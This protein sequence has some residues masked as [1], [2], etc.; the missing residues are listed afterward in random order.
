MY[1]QVAMDPLARAFETPSERTTVDDV[2]DCVNVAEVMALGAARLAPEVRNYLL[3]AAGDEETAAGNVDAFRR[4]RLRPRVLADLDGLSTA[5]SVLGTSVSMP[6]GI[7]PTAEHGLFHPDGEVGMARAAAE[8][9]VPFCVSTASSRPL[10]EIVAA[11]RA[12][13]WFQLYAGPDRSSTE[14]LVRRAVEAGCSAIV[15]TADVAIVG[16]R[17]REFASRRR[18]PA[19]PYYDGHWGHLVPGFDVTRTG[20][21][22]TWSDLHWLLEACDGCPLVL[23]GVLTA[24]DA[25]LAV[26]HGVSAIWVSN[27]GGRQ[28]DRTPAT[29]DVL[30]EIVDA[31]GRTEVYLDGGIR[32]GIDA[33]TALALG[34]RCVFVGR[35]AVLGLAADGQ[36]GVAAVLA[37]L[38]RELFISLALL[39]APTPEQLGRGHV[40]PA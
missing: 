39:G 33:A 26:D 7:S 9:G 11:G 24:Q 5:S 2:G 40:G 15:L 13:L 16:Y 23:K 25:A 14:S 38:R 4:R 34:A 8:A 27:H 10:E 6:I 32:R 18:Y 37:M 19:S 21:R 35:P 1:C 31:V 29:L 28:L 3:A 20:F 30:E 12:P 36:A 17:D 22:S